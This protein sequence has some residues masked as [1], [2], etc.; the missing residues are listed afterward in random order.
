MRIAKKLLFVALALLPM[1]ACAIN[2]P[3]RGVI[4]HGHTSAGD[5]GV[6]A[7]P[8]IN[9]L[10]VVGTGI[11]SITNP[12][13]TSST[14]RFWNVGSPT[15]QKGTDF[16]FEDGYYRVRP[17]YDSTASKI[18]ALNMDPD[19]NIGISQS[20]PSAKLSVLGGV[21]ASSATYVIA[22]STWAGQVAAYPGVDVP[23]SLSG[24]A[25]DRLGEWNGTTYTAQAG[26]TLFIKYSAYAIRAGGTGGRVGI[27]KNGTVVSS[28]YPPTG[29]AAQV[30]GAV[31]VDVAAGD[32]IT[33]EMIIDLNSV[34]AGT[35]SL[36]WLPSITTFLEIMGL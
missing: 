20:F 21:Q 15:N 19:G 7:N 35:A 34:T 2:Y 12:S 23:I 11:H 5:G 33:F 24:E 32:T 18:D 3:G 1:T 17:L 4:V 14:L 36:A 9:Q 25:V 10:S 8:V 26:Q 31:C 29:S 16:I 13:G 22:F 6:L 28:V 27:K 30:A